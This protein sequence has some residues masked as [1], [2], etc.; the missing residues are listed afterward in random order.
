M[1]LRYALL[2]L[3]LDERATGYELA[4]RFDSGVANFWHALPQQLYQELTRLEEEGLVEGEVVVQTARPNKRVFG[5]TQAGRDELAAWIE[6]PPRIRSTK[7]ELLVKI[8]ASD[9]RPPHEIIPL[10][11]D[12]IVAREEKVAHY[13]AL[14]DIMFHGRTEEQFLATTHRLGPYMALNR[15]LIYERDCIDWAR[16]AIGV[17]RARAASASGARRR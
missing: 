14:R 17:L 5:I 11:E 13:E 12:S 1:S 10:L 7:D 2:S 8:Y 3:L 9:L 6:Q 16:W 4:K 15:G